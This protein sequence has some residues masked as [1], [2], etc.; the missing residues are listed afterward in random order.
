[1]RVITKIS[2]EIQ[3][4]GDSRSALPHR[5]SLIV[6]DMTLGR[7]RQ[8]ICLW[9]LLATTFKPKY[10]NFGLPSGR[11]FPFHYAEEIRVRKVI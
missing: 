5:L 9:K 2:P 6:H 11:N 3:L 4:F 8:L 7:G 10:A 1:M